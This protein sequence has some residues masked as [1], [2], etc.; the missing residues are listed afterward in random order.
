MSPAPAGE[1]ADAAAGKGDGADETRLIGTPPPGPVRWLLI[2][3]GV[4]CVAL[5]IVGAVVPGLPTTIFL[6]L[7][8][9]AFARS[10]PRLHRWLW[11][12]PRFGPPLRA[13]VRHGVVSRRAKVAALSAMAVSLVIIALTSRSVVATGGVG[14]LLAGIGGWLARR[15]EATSEGGASQ[16]PNRSIIDK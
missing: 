6:I 8:L 3:A 11:T 4:A 10:S 5:G 16:Q 14:I 1:D 12:H 9:A 2:A 13:W 7:A 15:P